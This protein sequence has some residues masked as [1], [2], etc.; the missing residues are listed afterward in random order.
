MRFH[1]WSLAVGIQEGGSGCTA[2]QQ[3]WQPMRSRSCQHRCTRVRGFWRKRQHQ[4]GK[5]R[6]SA[7]KCCGAGCVFWAAVCFGCTSAA[8]PADGEL[9]CLSQATGGMPHSGGHQ[10]LSPT[11]KLV[12]VSLCGQAARLAVCAGAFVMPPQHTSTITLNVRCCWHMYPRR[13]T[14][15]VGLRRW[16]CRAPWCAR[17]PPWR[18]ILS[19]DGYVK[20]T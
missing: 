18:G 9:T 1:G 6:C 2:R 12:D 17:W 11:A 8:R 20:T 13:S 16:C 19:G 15:V 3:P 10:P 5:M 4:P 14:Q 7:W